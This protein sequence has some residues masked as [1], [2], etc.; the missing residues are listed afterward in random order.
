M[1]SNITRTTRLGNPSSYIR[2]PILN[3]SPAAVTSAIASEIQQN[4]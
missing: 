1:I 3:I 4:Q 2:Q